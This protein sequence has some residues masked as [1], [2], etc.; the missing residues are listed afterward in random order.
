MVQLLCLI[1][2]F[3]YMGQKKKMLR[4]NPA[5]FPNVPPVEFARW[6]QLE[7]KSIDTF[8]WATWGTFIV[9]VLV[10]IVSFASPGSIGFGVAQGALLGLFL[11]G[12]VV[13]AINGSK[14]ASLK[15]K[16]GISLRGH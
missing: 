16:L 1:M 2:G 15:K 11:L 8:L 3:V 6:R 12:L 9:G 13:S 10:G 5:Q 14:A 7:L 4:L